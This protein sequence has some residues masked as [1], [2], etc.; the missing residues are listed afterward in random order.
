MIKN[1]PYLMTGEKSLTQTNI[2]LRGYIDAYNRSHQEEPAQ[3]FFPGFEKWVNQKVKIQSDTALGI[4]VY[5]V[6]N[7]KRGGRV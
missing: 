4:K 6:Y 2:F 7:S 5:T 1:R 3:T